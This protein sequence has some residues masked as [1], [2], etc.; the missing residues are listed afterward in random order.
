M[1]GAGGDGAIKLWNS[2]TGQIIRTLMGHAKGVSDVA[3]A[4]NSI[5]IASASDDN[6]IRVWQTQL[7]RYSAVIICCV[8]EFD[9][10]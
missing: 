6:T 9:R 5:H 7:V 8:A 1:L 10:G 3:W 4:R 2:Y